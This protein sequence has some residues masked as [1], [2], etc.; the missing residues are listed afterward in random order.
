MKTV[1]RRSGS[2]PERKQRF[3]QN[4]E[5]RFLLVEKYEKMVY[6]GK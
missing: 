3:K 6:T 4:P 1:Y 5:N 2:E